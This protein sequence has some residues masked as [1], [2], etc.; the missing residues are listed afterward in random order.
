MSTQRSELAKLI[1][2]SAKS[3]GL[4]ET[5][6]PRLFVIR[7][8]TPTEPI[9][10]VYQPAVCIIAQGRKHATLGDAVYTY[11]EDQYLVISMDVPVIGQVIEATEAKPY[12]C[13]RFDLD[14]ATL[15]TLLLDMPPV[16]ESTEP[17]PALGVSRITPA[18]TDAAIRLL[19]LLD[20]PQDISVL[21]PLIEREL[22]FRL[23]Q[24]D[25]AAKLREI[26]TGGSRL[27]QVGR[28]IDFIK[29]NFRESFRVE[30]VADEARMSASALH[31]HFK[32]VTA[33]SPLQYQKQMRLQQARLLMFQGLCD[34]AAASHRV[35]YSSPS[36]FSREYRR[37]FG[38]PPQRDI[39]R[40]KELPGGFVG[41]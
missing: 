12:L 1:D 23:L 14:I 30:D 9:H 10:G 16:R 38:L 27:Q 36:Q 19:A 29:R 31:S 34:A 3:D 11:D 26:A 25:Q 41:A 17:A 8:S 18:L 37:L 32:A 6:V 20:T 35:G 40:L 13:I 15:G 33:M 4:H 5:A 21:A 22:L 2:R 39:A 7:S 28:A 24:G